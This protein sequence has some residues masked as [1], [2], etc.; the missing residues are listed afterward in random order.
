MGEAERLFFDRVLTADNQQD[1]AQSISR[2][3]Q[4]VAALKSIK[5]PVLIRFQLSEQDFSD[6]VS[7][8]D[9]IREAVSAASQLARLNANIRIIIDVPA[10]IQIRN[11]GIKGDEEMIPL[12]KGNQLA[13]LHRDAAAGFDWKAPANV[14]I[15]ASGNITIAGKTLISDVDIMGRL[16]PNDRTK[17]SNLLI[18]GA[19]LLTE[20]VIDI[21]SWLVLSHD[22]KGYA[23]DQNALAN[24]GLVSELMTRAFATRQTSQSA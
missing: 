15:A 18:A 5:E 20:H 10:G 2:A 24:F 13:I 3:K 11:L 17:S 23:K 16:L 14:T 4:I 21:S 1:L 9:V 7:P 12:F 22:E 19:V 8:I 6:S